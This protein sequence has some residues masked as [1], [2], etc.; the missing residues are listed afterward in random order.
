MEVLQILK[1]YNL[2]YITLV[3]IDTEVNLPQIVDRVPMIIDDKN[4]IIV[5]D[6]VVNFLTKLYNKS[7]DSISALINDQNSC[8]SFIDENEEKEF[9]VVNEVYNYLGDI[10]SND[11]SGDLGSVTN[12]ETQNKNKVNDKTLEQYTLER[13]NDDREIKSM[14]HRKQ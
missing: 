1:K 3:C 14:L 12:I 7:L 5:D 4:N 8:F 13:E 6:D 10:G 11:I 2:N 9:K